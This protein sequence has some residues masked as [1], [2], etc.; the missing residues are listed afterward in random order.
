MVRLFNST[1]NI[2][3]VVFADVYFKLLKNMNNEEKSQNADGMKQNNKG[4]KRNADGTKQN[5][6]REKAIDVRR[7]NNGVFNA[8]TDEE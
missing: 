7:M 6:K 5:N 3:I 2:Y 1:I 4:E 8:M